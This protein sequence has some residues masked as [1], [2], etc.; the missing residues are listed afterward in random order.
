[1][2]TNVTRAFHTYA[3]PSKAFCRE[4][5]VRSECDHHCHAPTKRYSS[6]WPLR[7]CSK[8]DYSA[9]CLDKVSSTEGIFVSLRLALIS[10]PPAI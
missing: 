7:M 2:P 6:A 5:G 10:F 9:L 8:L 4:R 1:M 3:A